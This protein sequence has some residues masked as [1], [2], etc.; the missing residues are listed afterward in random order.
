MAVQRGLPSA[1]GVVVGYVA[2]LLRTVSIDSGLLSR[3]GEVL[4]RW[5]SESY[6]ADVDLVVRRVGVS[7]IQVDG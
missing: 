2:C 5:C 4:S 7:G 3:K 6:G 1:T